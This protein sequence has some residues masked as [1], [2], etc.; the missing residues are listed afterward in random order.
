MDNPALHHVLSSHLTP[1]NRASLRGSSSLL[2]Q[3]YAQDVADFAVR[4][5]VQLLKA[6]SSRF[7][8]A[9]NMPNVVLSIGPDYI[10]ELPNWRGPWPPL[11]RIAPLKYMTTEIGELYDIDHNRYVKE[12]DKARKN[13]MMTQISRYI[14]SRPKYSWTISSPRPKPQRSKPWLLFKGPYFDHK[15]DGRVTTRQQFWKHSLR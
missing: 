11:E 14:R 12:R 10:R 4:R 13:F 8:L 3:L 1:R 9:H 6:G 5:L 15:R 7:I 2:R